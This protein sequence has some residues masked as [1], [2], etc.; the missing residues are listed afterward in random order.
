[1]LEGGDNMLN[2]WNLA[3]MDYENSLD[4]VY[5]QDYMPPDHTIDM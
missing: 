3:A 1:M 5:Y 4:G 2:K